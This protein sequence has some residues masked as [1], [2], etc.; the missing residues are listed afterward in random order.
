MEFSGLKAPSSG[1]AELTCHKRCLLYGGG[2]RG[3]SESSGELS[4]TPRGSPM[5]LLWL[6]PVRDF[7]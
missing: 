2:A 1:S 3:S 5:L 7:S 6:Q 4:E